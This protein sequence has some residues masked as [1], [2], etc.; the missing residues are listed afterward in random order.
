MPPARAKRGEG[1]CKKDG[2][3]KAR[4]MRTVC[5]STRERTCKSGRRDAKGYCIRAP[6]TEA[7]KARRSA[8]AKAN[9]IGKGLSRKIGIKGAKKVFG[10]FKKVMNAARIAKVA[11]RRGRS[12]GAMSTALVP[13]VAPSGGGA[14]RS[15]RLLK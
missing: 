4:R 14:R 1:T 13:Y 12:A 3:V 9:R 15:S 8:N 5:V 7:Q 6:L 11:A 10:V 2:Y